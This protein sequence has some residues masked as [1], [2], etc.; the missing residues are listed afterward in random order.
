MSSYR[1]SKRSNA[2][3]RYYRGAVSLA[4]CF[5]ATGL[6]FAEPP[7]QG[8]ETPDGIVN[9]A[10][11]SGLPRVVKEIKN[12]H[13][14]NVVA[15]GSSSTYGIGASARDK[16]FPA[17]LETMLQEQLP[18]VQVSVINLGVTGEPTRLAA[19]RIQL[20][21]MR[22]NPS[23]LIWQV[24]TIEGTSKTPVGEFELTLR[25]SLAFLR[26][27]GIDVILVDGQWTPDLDMSSHYKAIN[28]SVAR[29]ASAEHVPFVSR[30]QFMRGIGKRDGVEDMLSDGFHL[31]D[32][33]YERMAQLVASD[34]LCH[35]APCRGGERR[36]DPSL[37]PSTRTA[38]R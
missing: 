27:K 33:G 16:T 21:V 9:A 12:R 3:H 37:N 5:L 34:I 17:R 23:L 4:V 10:S 38:T 6:A 18:N 22:L 31:N 28:E 15:L 19:E 8:R 20:D 1:K 24:G 36:L 32:L 29:I 13:E 35:L 30:F 14:L 11:Q 7:V 26:E 25:K 2:L